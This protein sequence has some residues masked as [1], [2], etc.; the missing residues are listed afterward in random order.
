MQKLQIRCQEGDFTGLQNGDYV[1]GLDLSGIDIIENDFSPQAWNDTWKNNRFEIS[2][3]NHYKNETVFGTNLN[4]LTIGETVN[5][6]DHIIFSFVNFIARKGYNERNTDNFGYWSSN[7][8][9]P[10]VDNTFTPSLE[11]RLGIELYPL[12]KYHNN[13]ETSNWNQYKIWPM[14]LREIFSD[15]E[16]TAAGN[17]YL[18]EKVDGSNNNS[19]KL[20]ISNM[21]KKWKGNSG[22]SSSAYMWRT[23]LRRN[24][25][26]TAA[27]VVNNLTG[28]LTTQ[29]A[30]SLAGFAPAF[31]VSYQ[32]N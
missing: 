16:L 9:K 20:Y 29:N 18:L 30:T 1:D 3:I 19:K 10:W 14:S 15:D 24:N 22:V 6:K 2:G 21:F 31:C 7:V 17:D 32:G 23:M 26:N 28:L 11:Q 5:T 27:I 12:W 4:G 25:A 13:K 8:L